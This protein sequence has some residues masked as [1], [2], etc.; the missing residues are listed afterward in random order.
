MLTQVLVCLWAEPEFICLKE[1][2]RSIYIYIHTY[3]FFSPEVNFPFPFFELVFAS[4]IC[5]MS[6]GATVQLLVLAC[7]RKELVAEAGSKKLLRGLE[8]HFY[9]G[10]YGIKACI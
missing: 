7:K 4:S 1:T 3:I 5:K 8:M 9:M 6:L 10:L 2:H